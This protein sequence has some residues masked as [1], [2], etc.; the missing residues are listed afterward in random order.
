MRPLSL[1]G[2]IAT[3]TLGVLVIVLATVSTAAYYEFRESLARS[4]DTVLAP[5]ADAVRSRWANWLALPTPNDLEEILRESRPWKAAGLAAWIEG[6]ANGPLVR[7]AGAD[8]AH[9]WVAAL[10]YRA[11][12][13]PGAQRAQTIQPAGL[14][15]RAIW[16]RSSLPDG[17]ILSVIA[18]TPI[19]HLGHEMGEFLRLL[20]IL[21]G[22][23]LLG[24]SVLIA[25]AVSWALRPVG[26]TAARL[27]G[28]TLRN[29]GEEHLLGIRT[30]A[31]LRPFVNSLRAMLAR[32]SR[33]VEAR[34]RFV[35]DASH[36]LR[37]PLATAKSTIQAARLRTRTAE[38]YGRTL[39]DVLADIDR[40]TSLVS[41]LLDLARLEESPTEKPQSV[42]IGDL[43]REAADRYQSKVCADGGRLVCDLA[44]DG[45]AVRG[46]PAELGRLVG[47]LVENAAQHGPPGGTITLRCAAE[48][49]ACL[50][51][52]HD[53]GG[54]VPPDQIGRLFDRFYRA[55]ASRS[56]ASGGAGLGLAIARQIALRHGGEIGIASSPGEGTRVWVRLPMNASPDDPQRSATD[57]S[58]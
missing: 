10:S 34:K 7:T 44:A 38:E 45:L 55:D 36:E 4:S 18:A 30:S 56:R 21:G 17:R 57:H 49:G 15:C 12:P 24:A 13:A 48:G 6:D 22:G 33:G 37:T 47:N 54:H 50:L 53:E 29:L 16:M 40:L 58:D 8:S 2:R 25:L 1:K 26:L 32:V 9:L 43:L 14:P 31:E 39:D 52:V 35:A 51:S 5:V 46:S 27:E 42:A 41:Q 28:V 3:L 19:P 11:R 23:V 20:L